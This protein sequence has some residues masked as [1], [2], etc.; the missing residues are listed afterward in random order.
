MPEIEKL[1]VRLIPDTSSGDLKEP[2]SELRYAAE[3]TLDVGIYPRVHESVESLAIQRRL[4]DEVIEELL[5]KL[6]ARLDERCNEIN[7]LSRANTTPDKPVLAVIAGAG[8]SAGFGLPVTT[9]LPDLVA[10]PCD[11]PRSRLN[12]G[13]HHNEL[14]EYPLR[15]YLAR[16]GTIPDFEY[17]LTIWEAYRNQLL[18]SDAIKGRG[19]VQCYRSI[20]ENICCHLYRLSWAIRDADGFRTTFDA[21][22]R[23]LSQ[24]KRHYD[25]RFITFNYDVVLEMLCTAAAFPII[26]THRPDTEAIPIRKLHGSV[27]WQEFDS[28][29]DSP[30]AELTLLYESAQQ[31]IYAFPEVDR[32]PYGSSGE[33]PVLIPPTASKSYEGIYEWVWASAAHDISVADHIIVVGYSFPPLD[34]FARC[35]LRQVLQEKSG[36]ITYILPSGGHQNRVRKVLDGVDV[37][38][39]SD[40]WKVQHFDDALAR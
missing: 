40:K 34:A 27:N 37:D 2:L 22:V 33:M 25:V 4:S 18:Q 36:R 3:C 9:G 7:R 1:V 35:H 5:D 32:C 17:L 15:E 30:N 6:D 24:A 31:H 28:T 14:G 13:W 8:F 10:K 21:L 12:D 19:H 38:Y 11:K 23:W 16:D 20:I 26:Y 29:V 39:I